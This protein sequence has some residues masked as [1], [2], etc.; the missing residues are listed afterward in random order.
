MWICSL[1]LIAVVLALMGI[2]R[3]LEDT[4]DERAEKREMNR[5]ARAGHKQAMNRLSGI[6][7]TQSR[8]NGAQMYNKKGIR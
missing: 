3:W 2:G 8:W 6:N 1:I 4:E 5:K 7:P